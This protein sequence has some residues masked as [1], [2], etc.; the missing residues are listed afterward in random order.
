MSNPVSV[1]CP[2]CQARLRLAPEKI[3]KRIRCP[4]C[5]EPFTAQGD[6]D[7]FED[8]APVRTRRTKGKQPG[9]RGSKSAKPNS[10]L[11]LLIGAGAGTLVLVVGLIV[12]LTSGRKGPPPVAQADPA[13]PATPLPSQPAAAPAINTV[14]TGAG[15]PRALASLPDWLV[16]DAP[17]D[18][19]RFWVTVPAEQNAAPLYLDALYEFSPHMEVYFPADARSQ[20]TSVARARRERSQK[21]QVARA[22]SPGPQNAAERDA[23]LSDHAAGFQK[24]IAA[25]ARPR[26]VF[27]IGWDVP[28]FAP[29]CDAMREVARIAEIQIERDLEQGDVK[30]AI[31]LIEITSRLSRHLRVRTPTVLQYV[32]DSLDT[33]NQQK[34]LTTV[35]R[36]PRLRPADCE[37]LLKQQQQHVAELRATNPVLTGLQGDYVWRQLLIHDLQ[38][39]TGEFADDKFAT[40]F[41]VTNASRGAALVAALNDAQ[42]IIDIG[43]PDKT[44]QNTLD[45]L[46]TVMKPNDFTT[47]VTWQKEFYRTA[48]AAIDQPFATRRAAGQSMLDAIR[49][50]MMQEVQKRIP[51]DATPEQRQEGAITYLKEAFASG[52]VSIP[53]LSMFF[54]NR[55]EFSMSGSG[56]LF[57]QDTVR[58]TNQHASLVLIALR[59]WYGVSSEPPAD[60]MAICSAA[61]IS[62]VPTDEFSGGPLRLV[63]FSVETPIEDPYDKSR[64]AL[65][66]ESIVYSVGP[67]GRDDRALKSYGFRPDQPGDLLFPLGISQSAF[68][69]TAK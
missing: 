18:V 11:P 47:N 48:S 14:P 2:N 43:L 55:F 37:Q 46:L 21:L 16:K 19:A 39:R 7:D 33:I 38:H 52:N 40:A 25:Q 26:C 29:L 20:R 27:E 32:A 13:V 69:P 30:S 50:D 17:F 5:T 28:S 10:Q 23:V 31:Q 64:K 60:A 45:T 59:R 22:Q 67:D 68:A 61:G 24:L 65:A 8:E 51:A 34:L 6:E 54:R 57:E 36:S 58:L 35:L 15:F 1:E 3:G 42:N 63:T 44:M 4:K 41:G 12:Y 49:R 53:M 66:G 62:P 9:K 56:S